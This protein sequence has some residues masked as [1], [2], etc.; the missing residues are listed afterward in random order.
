MTDEF[1]AAIEAE[2]AKWGD[3]LPAHSVRRLMRQ[4]SVGRERLWTAVKAV[5]AMRNKEATS[6]TKKKKE[7]MAIEKKPS[8]EVVAHSIETNVYDGSWITPA[9]IDESVLL[10]PRKP[11]NPFALLRAKR[12]W[13]LY[14]GAMPTQDELLKVQEQLIAGEIEV[15]TELAD[16]ILAL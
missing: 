12:A 9:M 1:K 2:M 13:K 11:I 3:K 8:D 5:I 10:L 16:L 4:N 15:E 14:A 6:A 7:G